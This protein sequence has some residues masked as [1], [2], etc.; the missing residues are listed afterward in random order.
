M[1]FALN[2]EKKKAKNIENELKETQEKLKE[3]I[4]KN[5]ELERILEEKHEENNQITNELA[6][7]TENKEKIEEIL[8]EK[9]QVFMRNQENF[10]R[11]T[12]EIG[13]LSK[14]LEEK[15]A[16]TRNQYKEIEKLQRNLSAQQEKCEK[17]QSDL[18]ISQNNFADFE[19][20]SKENSK[21]M[22]QSL[23]MI[24][25]ENQNLN[26]RLNSLQKENFEK[27]EEEKKNVANLKKELYVFELK[28]A[29]KEEKIQGLERINEKNEEFLKEIDQKYKSASQ[30]LNKSETLILNKENEKQ[31]AFSMIKQM[32]RKFLLIIKEKFS[33]IKA[34]MRRLKANSDA[35]CEEYQGLIV[36]Q[37]S[38]L[39]NQIANYKR[40]QMNSFEEQNERLRYE[41]EL[42]FQREFLAIQQKNESYESEM[43]RKYEGQFEEWNRKSMDLT[44]KMEEIQNGSK[45]L[46]GEIYSLIKEKEANIKEIELLKNELEKALVLNQQI[47]KE[48]SDLINNQE[49]II[50]EF[51]GKI[52][53]KAKKNEKKYVKTLKV[54]KKNV[55]TLQEKNI[56]NLTEINEGVEAL[57]DKYDNEIRVL[58]RNSNEKLSVFKEKI[59]NYEGLLSDYKGKCS[60]NE[61]II[62]EKERILNEIS[63]EKEQMA[64]RYENH[65]Y[66]MNQNLEEISSSM[67]QEK[68]KF[69]KELMDKL[70]EIDGL[71]NKGNRLENDL[72]RKEEEIYTMRNDKNRLN[73]Q[74]EE[75]LIKYN[76]KNSQCIKEVQEQIQEKKKYEGEVENL[77][78]LLTKKYHKINQNK[79]EE[80]LNLDEKVKKLHD[81]EEELKFSLRTKTVV[82]P[83]RGKVSTPMIRNKND[84]NK[85]Y[86]SNLMMKKNL[87]S[88][89]K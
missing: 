32:K 52:Q 36:Q 11:I 16:L 77:Q 51:V 76:M 64:L 18:F 21:L 68:E 14:S 67:R 69:T 74:Y 86:Y 81:L 42:R 20:S 27:F 79:R 31:R 65:I 59:T 41:L 23:E 8:Q 13:F 60:Y 5:Q 38:Y 9:E 53:E 40:N 19:N 6:V 10:D 25:F 55:E 43:K 54:L 44:R 33:E 84:F 37:F 66:I 24:T 46:Q 78:N 22:K 58:M 75:A 12:I 89:K 63:E 34:H 72:K 30:A 88:D 80:A 15:E 4:N 26:I 71:K 62:E 35:I 47:N 83:E 57:Q 39:P 28:L 17:L 3:I 1:E 82:S 49:K 50:Q 73:N 45:K 7:L 87:G 61:N 85:Q 70:M 48:K 29:E 56:K 2:E